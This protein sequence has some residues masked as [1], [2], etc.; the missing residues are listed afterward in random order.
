[1]K[2]PSY[3]PNPEQFVSSS[4]S[5]SLPD[6]AQDLSPKDAVTAVNDWLMDQV[7]GDATAEDLLNGALQALQNAGFPITRAFFAF[8]VLHPLFDSL[9]FVWR[10][11]QDIDI[12][13]H[14]PNEEGTENA[15]LNSPQ[16]YLISQAQKT[17]L[18]RAEKL[19]LR[20]RLS[21]PD[22]ELDFDILKQLAADGITDYLAFVV[23]YDVARENGLVGSWSTDRPEG[24][25]DD[26]IKELR[27]FESRLAVA[28]K[29]RSGEAIARSVVDTYLGP[30]AGQKVLRGGIRRGDSQSIDAIIWYSDLRESTALSERLSP[31]EFLELLDSYF[32][33]TAGAA[34]AEG[35][36][37]LTMIGDAVLAIFPLHRFDSAKAAAQAALRAAS[38]AWTRA[39][40]TSAKR[41]SQNKLPFR[42]GLGLHVGDL[43]Y[44]NIGVPERL[45]FTAVGPNVNVTARLEGLTRPLQSCIL[46]TG[47]FAA[48]LPDQAWED[49]GQHLLRGL[50]TPVPV[51]SI[52]PPDK[53]NSQPSVPGQN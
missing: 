35:G 27:R 29:A 8:K 37:V 48:L 1:M 36:E 49:K 4:V 34:L 10:K 3:L 7:L 21:G 30:D 50:S 52:L 6:L 44:G 28:L 51:L 31:L 45:Q 20:R 23:V 11:G 26:Q 46:V 32:E 22:A 18:N 43:L 13:S 19:R 16:N 14:T 33:C 24:F 5:H 41:R 42:F 40:E 15:F 17:G 25:S 12:E 53:K 9:S 39:E 38:L 2:S 47:D